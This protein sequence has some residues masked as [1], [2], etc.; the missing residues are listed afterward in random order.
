MNKEA[1]LYTELHAHT[2]THTHTHRDITQSQKRMK[3]CYLQQYG[4][5]CEEFSLV[6]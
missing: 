6:K 2:H 3:I 5:T 1:V 4:W